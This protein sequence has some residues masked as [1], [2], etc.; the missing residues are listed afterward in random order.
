VQLQGRPFDRVGIT[1]FY[2]IHRLQRD[3]AQKIQA[4][5]PAMRSLALVNTV[6]MVVS[7]APVPDWRF[8]PSKFPTTAPT[9]VQRHPEVLGVVS[10]EWRVEPG[11]GEVDQYWHI[12]E[13][14]F[15]SDFACS[16]PLTP[17]IESTVFSQD[18]FEIGYDQTAT[19]DGNCTTAWGSE[20]KSLDGWLGYRFSKPVAVHCVEMLQSDCLLPTPISIEGHS[21]PTITVSKKLEKCIPIE[22]E[23]PNEDLECLSANAWGWATVMVSGLQAPNCSQRS[24]AAAQTVL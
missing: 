23:T 8:E 17:L 5:A 19:Y 12:A 1:D 10:N 22:G 7:S 20:A 13:L 3:P 6:L 15:Y 14:I 2:L 16:V 24:S 21:S 18:M 11:E 4:C 9:V